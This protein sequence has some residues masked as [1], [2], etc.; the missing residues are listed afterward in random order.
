MPNPKQRIEICSLAGFNLACGLLAIFILAVARVNSARF[1][2]NQ[3][4]QHSEEVQTYDI[5][6]WDL[7][8]WACDMKDVVPLLASRE[9]HKAFQKQCTIE[10]AETGILITF[11]SLV[12]FASI[13]TMCANKKS[14]LEKARAE[15]IEP[16]E[17]WQSDHTGV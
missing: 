11:S 14:R 7:Q 6:S 10:K 15:R 16:K 2:W 4:D 1:D 8:T 13:W 9:S 5:G 3:I 12:F 17:D